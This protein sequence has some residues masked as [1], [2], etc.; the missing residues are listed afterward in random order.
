M[1]SLM[2][3]LFISPSLLASQRVRN[4]L[5]ITLE[6][7]TVQLVVTGLNYV[8]YFLQVLTLV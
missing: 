6:S 7:L 5:R 8:N 4:Q 2:M 3:T 1:I